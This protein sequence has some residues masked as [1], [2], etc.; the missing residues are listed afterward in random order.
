MMSAEE[1]DFCELKL[2]EKLP[3]TLPSMLRKSSNIC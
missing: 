3:L 1:T 2:I